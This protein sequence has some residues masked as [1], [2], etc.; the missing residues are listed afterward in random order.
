MMIQVLAGSTGCFSE[1]PA[2]RVRGIPFDDL[3]RFGGH[4]KRAPPN[5]LLEGPACQVRC[6]T[7]DNLFC[8]NSNSS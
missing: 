1:G 3:F 5:F 2:C 8:F 4:D 6:A 7:L